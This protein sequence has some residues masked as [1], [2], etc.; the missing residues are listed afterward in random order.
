MRETEKWLNFW[1]QRLLIGG[2]KSSWRSVT[3]GVAQELLLFNTFVS[4]L[5][6][7]T[8]CALSK[9]ADNTKFGGVAG[10]PAGCVSIQKALDMLEKW[11]KGNLLHFNNGK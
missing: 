6:G 5:D 11:G 7:K 1:V 10:T 9:F 8:K 2:R 3:S 4:D